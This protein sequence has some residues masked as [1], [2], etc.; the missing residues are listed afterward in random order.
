[1]KLLAAFL[2]FVFVAC[3][4]ESSQQARWD[5][6]RKASDDSGICV[7]HHV[8]LQRTVVYQW[9]HFD[10]TIIDPYE[11]DLRAQW[12]YPNSLSYIYRRMPSADF[13]DKKIEVYCPVCQQRFEQET[14]QVLR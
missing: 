14:H 10:T 9:S 8:P 13:H 4:S 7:L 6:I 12:K 3:E 5:Q 11:A 2:P 1:M